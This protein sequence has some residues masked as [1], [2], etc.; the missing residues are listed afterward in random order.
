VARPARYTADDLLDAAVTLCAAEG[1]AAVA[2]AGVAR[3]VG[4][5]SGSVYHR[6]PTRAAL[7]GALWLRTEE[8]FQAGFVAELEA[9]GDVVERC[10]AAARYVVGWCRGHPDDAQVLLVGPGA[11]DV[12][13]WPASVGDRRA[14]LQRTLAAAMAGLGVDPDRLRAAVIDVPYG[15][16]RRHLVARQ[17]IPDTANAIVEDCARA[18]ISMR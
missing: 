8:R 18:L 2:M 11:L 4:A 16:V 3:A 12:D 7:C 13:D 1:P 9:D 14:G 15:V 17:T 5:P 10:V 6:F